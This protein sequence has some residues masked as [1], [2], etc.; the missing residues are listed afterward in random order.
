MSELRLPCR[1]IGFRLKRQDQMERVRANS[2]PQVQLVPLAGFVS[3]FVLP[4]RSVRTLQF[5]WTRSDQV[6]QERYER[7]G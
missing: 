2:P 5:V 1:A 6:Q 3:R 7:K 4:A